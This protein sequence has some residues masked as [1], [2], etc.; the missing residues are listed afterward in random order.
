MLLDHSKILTRGRA[1]RS[2]NLVKLDS[3]KAGAGRTSKQEQEKTKQTLFLPF[4]SQYCFE[5]LPQNWA[6]SSKVRRGWRAR[7]KMYKYCFSLPHAV[8]WCFN[9]QVKSEIVVSR[10]ISSFLCMLY[11]AHM[12]NV[13]CSCH[14][15]QN[16]RV[17]YTEQGGIQNFVLNWDHWLGSKKVIVKNWLHLLILLIKK[18]NWR[19]NSHSNLPVS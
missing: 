3:A 14:I 4:F 15:H 5:K 18:C 12:A 9:N 11:E 6:E 17:E 16:V 2:T 1:K 7:W 10:P 19:K 13:A 8:V